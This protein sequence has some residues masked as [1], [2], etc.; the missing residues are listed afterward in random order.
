MK[1]LLFLLLSLMPLTS[2]SESKT[3][4]TLNLGVVNGGGLDGG[5]PLDGDLDSWENVGRNPSVII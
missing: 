1:Y 5:F 3:E 4:L 2:I